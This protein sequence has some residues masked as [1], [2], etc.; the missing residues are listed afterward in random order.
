MQS[1][2]NILKK[3]LISFNLNNNN[4]NI[5]INDNNNLP[6]RPPPSPPP[7]PP[8]QDHFFQPS[9]PPQQ[10][11]PK[12]IFFCTAPR[13]S[14]LAIST[15]ATTWWLFFNKHKIWLKFHRITRKSNWKYRQCIK[16]GPWTTRNRTSR[17]A[18]KCC[19]Y[20]GWWNFTRWLY[21]WSCIKWK[22][23][24]WRNKRCI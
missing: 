23:N 9:F 22:K 12:Q 24:N 5:N 8:K 2:L 20:K 16:Q 17:F 1:R 4:N 21:K 6:P 15:V 10:A 7:S 18:N 13:I 3:N 14:P 11:T 19:I